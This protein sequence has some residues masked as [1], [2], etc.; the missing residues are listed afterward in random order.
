MLPIARFAKPVFRKPYFGTAIRPSSAKCSPKDVLVGH[1]GPSG[2]GTRRWRSLSLFVAFPALGLAMANVFSTPSEDL[3]REFVPYEHLYKRS[4]RF[5][6]G[7]GKE[8]LFHN[9]H[10]NALP[11]QGFAHK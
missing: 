2:A 5:P 1:G 9:D 6:W 4:K 11:G 10:T 8:S 7:E 3:D